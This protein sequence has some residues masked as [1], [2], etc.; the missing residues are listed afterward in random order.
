MPLK[1]SES[2]YVFKRH[3]S[4]AESNINHV[5]VT[6]MNIYCQVLSYGAQSKAILQLIPPLL[7]LVLW[8]QMISDLSVLDIEM[9]PLVSGGPFQ[10]VEKVYWTLGQNFLLLHDYL[11]CS[12]LTLKTALRSFR[13]MESTTVWYKP[14][15]YLLCKNIPC[16][17]WKALFTRP[18]LCGECADVLYELLYVLLGPALLLHF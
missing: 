18:R 16:G 13:G 17:Y 3:C 12:L 9:W 7:S 14:L 1:W 10:K 8:C 11:C 15:Q 2:L 4:P 5:I 6:N